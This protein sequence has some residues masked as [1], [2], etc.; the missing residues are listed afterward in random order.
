MARG[1]GNIARTIDE[2]LEALDT[3]IARAVTH[4]SRLGYFAVLYREVTAKVKEGIA[5]GFFD[6]GPRMERLDVAFANR[7]LAALASWEK[8]ERPS[9]SWRLAFA[10]AAHWRP[11]VLQHLLLG[12]NAHINL[13][14]GIAAAAIA[15]AAEHGALRDDFDRINEILFALVA[16]VQEEIGEISPWIGA[17][18]RVGGVVG[19]EIIKFSLEVARNEAWT[20]SS[21]LAPLPQN[22]WGNLIDLRDREVSFVGERVLDPGIFLSAVLFVIRCRES[23][24]VRKNLRLLGGMAAPPLET[25][26]ARRQKRAAGG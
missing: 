20:F 8:V 19:D 25:I 4:G 2:V 1:D 21:E 13:D 24:D 7:Y 22:L 9:R 18:N 26:E 3:I 17:L 11:I 23:G 12:I 6:D 14:L 10:A 5:A 16:R 15:P